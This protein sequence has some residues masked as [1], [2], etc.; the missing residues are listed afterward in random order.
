MQRTLKRELKVPEIAKGEPVVTPPSDEANSVRGWRGWVAPC[1]SPGVRRL[2]TLSRS[3]AHFG[4]VRAASL[5][6]EFALLVK[7][8]QDAAGLIGPVV[9]F[10]AH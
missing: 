7:T 1:T 8:L 3:R 6:A 2:S 4:R 9:A 5:R 10:S